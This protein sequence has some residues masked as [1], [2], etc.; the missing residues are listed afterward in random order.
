M[1]FYFLFF[2]DKIQL[3]ILLKIILMINNLII[4]DNNFNIVI[5]LNIYV[6]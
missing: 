6:S 4:I 3:K 2:N 5:G 1:Y